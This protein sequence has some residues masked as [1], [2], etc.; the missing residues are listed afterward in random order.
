MKYQTENFAK[1]L[2]EVNEDHLRKWAQEIE[3]LLNRN[4]EKYFYK[5]AISVDK[6]ELGTRTV[7]NIDR[8]TISS[9]HIEHFALVPQEMGKPI[10]DMEDLLYAI[11]D[12]ILSRERSKSYV[13]G[14]IDGKVFEGKYRSDDKADKSEVMNEI[15]AQENKKEDNLEN[16]SFDDLAHTLIKDYLDRE[17]YPYTNEDIQEIADIYADMQ[18]FD[19]E[20]NMTTGN[21]VDE[22]NDWLRHTSEIGIYFENKEQEE[23]DDI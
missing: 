19:F 13:K 9:G 12:E 14:D 22:I 5:W 1:P 21:S 11:N 17:G 3:E 15:S 7:V 6:S 2:Q 8:T 16:L 18:E 23:R 10:R 20:G 4:N